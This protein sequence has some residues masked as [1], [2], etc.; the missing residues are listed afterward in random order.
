MG[1]VLDQFSPIFIKNRF[2]LQWSKVHLSDSYI[3]DCVFLEILQKKSCKMLQK[4]QNVAKW[5][6]NCIWGDNFTW[7]E[8]STWGDNRIWGEDHTWREVHTL[9]VEQM[10][11]D[12]WTLGDDW[13]LGN[14]QMLWDEQI[15][16]NL[17][18][19]INDWWLSHSKHFP[20][21]F[22]NLLKII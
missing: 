20:C 19:K 7:R 2:V 14:D 12:D 1:N 16:S 17:L 18:F 4:M 6:E 5:E 8:N 22:L 3:L 11:E 9:G 21:L 15:K 10:G 13:M